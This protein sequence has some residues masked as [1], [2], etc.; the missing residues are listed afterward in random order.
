M[1]TTSIGE[2]IAKLRNNSGLTQKELGDKLNITAQAVSK[3]ENGLSEPDIDT[4]KKLSAIFN[5][6]VSELVDGEAYAEAATAQATAAPA[7]AQAAA[8]P[9]STPENIR[10]INGYCERCKKPVAPGEYVVESGRG[11]QH[12]YCNECAQKNRIENRISSANNNLSDHKKETRRS[13][14]FG[15]IAGVVVLAIMLISLLVGSDPLPAAEAVPISIV[16]ALCYFTFI[17]QMFW[18][19][20]VQ[21]LFFFFL[22]SFK[23]PG[24]I[25]TLDIEGLLFLIFVKL[26]FSFL[27]IFLSIVWFLLGVL[28]IL[29]LFSLVIYPFA[30]IKHIHKGKKYK[31]DFNKAKA[32][33]S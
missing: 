30:L 33:Q 29:P 7:A 26:L 22:K 28:I 11:W 31:V 21:D 16:Y 19:G 3:W 25:F 15:S 8:A 2:R 4:L 1:E 24:V 12:I 14:I 27:S 9:V 5:I 20:V 10:I 6:S 17:G 18:D 23:M 13:L 32:E